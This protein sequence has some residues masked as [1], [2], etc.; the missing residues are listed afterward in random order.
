MARESQLSNYTT[1][2]TKDQLKGKGQQGTKWVSES[3]KNLLFTTYVQLPKNELSRLTE[4]NFMVSYTLFSMV[5]KYLSKR[6]SI[7]W[8]NDIMSYK[9]KIAGI[10]IE[11]IVSNTELKCFIGIGLNVNQTKFPEHLPNASSMRIVA[12]KVFDTDLLLK[13]FLALLKDNTNAFLSGTL[14]KSKY[15]SYLFRY[16]IPSMFCADDRIFMGKII[17]VSNNGALVLET[18]DEKVISYGLKEV[19]MIL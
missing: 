8:P 18:E 12:N 3:G 7:K 6:L 14:Y 1:V 11:N 16:N 2:V 10:L 13:E 15:M 9:N 17:D 4:F 19:K 5:N